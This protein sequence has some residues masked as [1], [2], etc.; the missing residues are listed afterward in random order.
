MELSRP[1]SDQT[2]RCGDLATLTLHPLFALALL[3]VLLLEFRDQ[4]L[5][6][7]PGLTHGIWLLLY[8]KDGDSI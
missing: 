8:M 5:V 3:P 1:A 6:H 7:L 2:G 4:A